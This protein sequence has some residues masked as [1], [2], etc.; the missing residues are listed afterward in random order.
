MVSSGSCHLLSRFSEPRGGERSWFC[1]FCVILVEKLGLKTFD[2]YG[3]I[4]INI[5]SVSCSV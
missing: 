5:V 2:R 3:I 4:Y 1:L